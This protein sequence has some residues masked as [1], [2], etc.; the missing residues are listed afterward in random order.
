M[1]NNLEK[2]QNYFLIEKNLDLHY[3]NQAQ[4]F[5]F[6]F[7][8]CG[9]AGCMFEREEKLSGETLSLHGYLKA[10]RT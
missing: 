10:V 5:F 1:E 3:F 7:F 4:I 2:L 6:F 8:W 9:R